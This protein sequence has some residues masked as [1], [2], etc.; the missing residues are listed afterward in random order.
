[1][2]EK[3]L[4]DGRVYFDRE[5]DLAERERLASEKA[6]LIEKE[7]AKMKEAE[8]KEAEKKAEPRSTPQG[9]HRWRD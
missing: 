4:I 7:K 2:V 3:V 8:R 9:R 6:A 5:K 1:M